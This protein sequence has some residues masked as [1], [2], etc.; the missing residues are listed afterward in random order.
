MRIVCDKPYHTFKINVLEDYEF[1]SFAKL[2]T[3]W[4]L[5]YYMLFKC[6]FVQVNRNLT[7]PF[8]YLLQLLHIQSK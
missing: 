8:T 6:G 2:C 3:I 5:S 7:T 4:T 1:K